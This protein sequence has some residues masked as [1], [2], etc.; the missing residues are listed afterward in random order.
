VLRDKMQRTMQEDAAVFRTQESLES[1]CRR[2]SEIWSEM[3]DIKVTDRSLIWNSDL[4]ETLELRQ[5][6]G[7]RDHDVVGAEARKESR[8]SHARED[9]TEGPFAG[10]DDENWRK[11]TL[12]WVNDAGRH[13]VEARLLRPA[14]VRLPM[15]LKGSPNG[16][17]SAQ[18]RAQG[19]RL[20][21]FEELRPW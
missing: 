7:Q 12:A 1:G 15:V 16:H 11:H 10:R 2:M 5:P 19:T 14:G 20:L 18:D 17:R 3:A 8:G 13:Y 21:I 9:Y 6:D 4:V